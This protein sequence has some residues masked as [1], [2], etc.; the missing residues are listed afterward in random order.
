MKYVSYERDGL[1]S[2]GVF[3]DG[4]VFDIPGGA[5]SFGSKGMANTMLDFLD[6]F[7]ENHKEVTGM[8]D[9]ISPAK[10]PELYFPSGQASLLAPLPNPRSLRLFVAFRTHKRSLF[11]FFSIPSTESDSDSPAFW[12]GNHQAIYGPGQ[13][14]VRPES[15]EQLDFGMSVAV[16]IGKEGHSIPAD[17]AHNHIAGY[18]IL[19]HWAA[20]DVQR[21]NLQQGFWSVKGADFATSFGPYLVT[22]DEVSPAQG[23]EQLRL[24]MD[25][26]ISG[27]NYGSD[28]TSNMDFSFA[29]MIELASRDCTLYPGD[30]ISA[31]PAGSGSLLGLGQENYEWLQPGDAVSLQVERIGQLENSIGND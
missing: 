30:V 13:K 17:D 26:M 2:I 27:N 3:V 29:E 14:I 24:R 5:R 6:D 16:I 15:T 18:T 21:A 28:N 10:R 20:R 25:V 7:R 11:D 1:R 4:R 12:F 23:D 19:N 22:K 8:L 31:G 9:Q